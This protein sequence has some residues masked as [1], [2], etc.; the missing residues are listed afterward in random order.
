MPTNDSAICLRTTDFSETSQIVYLLTRAGGVQGLM[1]KGSKRAKSSSGGRI[2]LFSEGDVAFIPGKTGGTLGTLTEFAETASHSDLRADLPRLNTGLYMLELC[3]SLLAEADPH[4]EVFDLLHS[5]LAR[6]GQPDASSPAVLAYF[7]YRILRHVGLLANLTSCVSCGK[8]IGEMLS[9]IQ[10][11]PRAVV[12]D[13]YL[14][15]SAGGLL[16]RDCEVSAPEK[17]LVN[18]PAMAALAALLAAEAGKRPKLPDT[19]AAA[20]NRLLTYHIQ[21]QLGKKLKT[22][23]RAVQDQSKS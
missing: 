10:G 9:A 16:C 14:S 19:H 12:R 1:A 20:V 23:A 4:P 5:A 6:L 11:D 18:P 17:Y 15:S 8:S 3:S 13:V 7:Q 2:D 22:A 21:Y